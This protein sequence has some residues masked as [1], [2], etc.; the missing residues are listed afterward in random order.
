MKKLREIWNTIF[1]NEKDRRL[2]TAGVI[3]L[4][5]ICLFI[6]AISPVVGGSPIITLTGGAEID[7]ECGTEFTEPGVKATVKDEDISNLIETSGSV[8]TSKL[9]QYEIEYKVKYKKRKV[10]KRRIVNVVD[11]TG[12][13][14]TLNG[15]AKVVVPSSI[16]EY[17]EPGATAVDASDG[18]V[19]SNI[20]TKMEQV[21]D[22]TWKVIYTVKDSHDN[23]ST[24]EREVCLQDTEAPQITL[25]GDADITIKEQ[26]KYEDAGVTAVDDRDGDLTANVTKDGYVDIYRSGTYTI[27]YTVTDSSGNTAQATRN[28]TVEKVEANTGDAI[29]LTFDDGP[30]SD[31]TVRILDT[32]KTNGIKA[33]FFICDYDEDKLPIIKRMIDEGHTIGI[34]GYSH[35]YSEIYTSVDAFMENIN[36]LKNKLKEDTGYDA[37]AIRFP[38]GSSNTVSEKYCQGVM[39]QLAQRVTDDGLMY[40]DWN[41]SSG[42]AE[43]N[44]RPVNLIIG[45]VTGG[46]KHGRNNVVLMH[47]TSAKQ[48]SA[49]A[50]QSIITYG[51]NNGYSFY[52]I[53]KDTIPVHHGI[54]N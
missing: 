43:G 15:D 48:T 17:Q 41:V 14:I 32:L 30:S 8:D 27:T 13:V 39:T 52:P 28:V 23:E 19:S 3:A 50:L 4:V 22:Y 6:L 12:P 35:E 34:H 40:M 7:A 31:V 11:H 1:D 37:F 44:N 51:K 24:A 46:F 2:M 54:N 45:N 47:D 33:T 18:D 29:Y 16:D 38:G 21:N 26:E 5:G 36:K 53:S 10:S 42:D 9:G 49:D 25:N 20:N